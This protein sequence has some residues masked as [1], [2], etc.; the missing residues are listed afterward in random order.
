MPDDVSIDTAA[1][2]V[3]SVQDLLGN[4]ASD[5]KLAWMAQLMAAQ[6]RMAEQSA[7][8]ADARQS[9][10]DALKAALEQAEARAARLQRIARR[11]AAELDATQ[12]LLSDLAAAFGACGLCWGE[13]PD[14]P[15]CRGR[16]RPGRFAPDPA[17]RL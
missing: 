9:E 13:D 15:S 17:L 8:T 7:P 11:L 10:L 2:G 16:G 3:P 5:P 1:L 14:C 12:A 6:R 4:L